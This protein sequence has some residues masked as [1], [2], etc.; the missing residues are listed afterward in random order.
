MP[1]HRSPIPN[2]CPHLNPSPGND[3]SLSFFPSQLMTVSTISDLQSKWGADAIA[4]STRFKFVNHKFEP[5]HVFS[6]SVP[7]WLY[8]AWFEVDDEHEPEFPCFCDDYVSVIALGQEGFGAVEALVLH[9][10]HHTPTWIRPKRFQGTPYLPSVPFDPDIVRQVSSAAL[11]EKQPVC[12]Q[13][14]VSEIFDS[15][16]MFE[17]F[18]YEGRS[19][20]AWVGID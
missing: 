13:E 4:A 3:P 1:G 19:K 7:L 14:T 2:R 9:P 8:V 16:R 17:G 12:G 20:S 11:V 5:T 18:K 6:P 15:S 10:Y